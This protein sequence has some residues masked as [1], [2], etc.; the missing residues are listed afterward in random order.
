MKKREILSA[1]VIGSVLAAPLTFAA[2]DASVEYVTVRTTDFSGKPPFTRRTETLPATAVAKLEPAPLDAAAGAEL[3]TVR[4]TNFS[5]K[6]PFA[7]RTET[8]TVAEVARLEAAGAEMTKRID[9]AGR[10]SFRRDRSFR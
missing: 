2:D 8:L 5:G 3:V 1:I 7:R 4:T 6:P 9:T 10:P